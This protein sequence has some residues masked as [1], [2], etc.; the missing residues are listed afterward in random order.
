MSIIRFDEINNKKKPSSDTLAGADTLFPPVIGL[1]ELIEVQKCAAE[2]NYNEHLRTAEMFG[3][4][5]KLVKSLLERANI[6][7]PILPTPDLVC[8]IGCRIEELLPSFARSY[9]GKKVILCSDKKKSPY[10]SVTLKLNEKPVSHPMLQP[11]VIPVVDMYRITKGKCEVLNTDGWKR[12]SWREYVG[13][14]KEQWADITRDSILDELMAAVNTLNNNPSNNLWAAIKRTNYDLCQLCDIDQI[15]QIASFETFGYDGDGL[16]KIILVPFNRKHKGMAIGMQEGKLTLF[17]MGHK[18]HPVTAFDDLFE[19]AC[20][21]KNHFYKYNGYKTSAILP[22]SKKKLIEID[23]IEL[24]SVY[25]FNAVVK[26]SFSMESMTE[27][28]RNM[29]YSAKETYVDIVTDNQLR[30]GFVSACASRFNRILDEAIDGMF[31]T[32]G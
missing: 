15:F 31:D 16:P 26:D 14:T 22:L 6:K 25:D 8:M 21:I 1:S 7:E 3:A 5:D 23:D 32:D 29:I 18:L 27:E 2:A 9:G 12:S 11:D 20:F 19:A 17:L 24:F 30:D 10:Y 13:L 4:V 28:E